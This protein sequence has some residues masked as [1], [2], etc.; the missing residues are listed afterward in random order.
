MSKPGKA[1]QARPDPLLIFVTY[2]PEPGPINVL[3]PNGKPEPG[4]NDKSDP[5]RPGFFGPG[6]GRVVGPGCPCQGLDGGYRD[7]VDGDGDG[8]VVTPPK[9]SRVQ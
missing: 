1:R 8:R 6:S 7:C 2:K 3:S 5:T 9:S 4:P